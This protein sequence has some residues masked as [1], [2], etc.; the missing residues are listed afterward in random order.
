[1]RKDFQNAHVQLKKPLNFFISH[2]PGKIV[3]IWCWNVANWQLLNYWN[4]IFCRKIFFWKYKIFPIK[5]YFAVQKCRIFRSSSIQEGSLFSLSK[6]VSRI[7]WFSWIFANIYYSYRKTFIILFQNK[8]G[9]IYIVM[10]HHFSTIC[11]IKSSSTVQDQAFASIDK[12]IEI[13][14]RVI[15]IDWFGGCLYNSD[16]VTIRTE[17]IL[18]LL[19]F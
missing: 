6:F 12:A 14:K 15:D 4:M 18:S 10:T 2:F 19:T 3:K 5:L 9:L 13:F 1:M 7:M 16:W 17:L 11:D 8:L